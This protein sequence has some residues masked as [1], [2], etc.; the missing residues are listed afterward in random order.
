[1]AKELFIM[2]NFLDSQYLPTKY[3]FLHEAMFLQVVVFIKEKISG[4]SSGPNKNFQW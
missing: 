3:F 2:V 4:N 1:M